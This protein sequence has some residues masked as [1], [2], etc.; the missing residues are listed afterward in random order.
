LDGYNLSDAHTQKIQRSIN[1]KIG[2]NESFD[3]ITNETL[4]A[5]SDAAFYRFSFSLEEEITDEEHGN[6]TSSSN[7]VFDAIDFNANIR[8]F[9]NFTEVL[10]SPLFLESL[11][12]SFVSKRKSRRFSF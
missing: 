11:K 8:F 2:Y 10:E 12:P 5:L 9:N 7:Q 4:K 3:E 6:Y 1:E